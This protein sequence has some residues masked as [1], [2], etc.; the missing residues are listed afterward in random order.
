MSPVRR[1]EWASESRFA[2]AQG[3]GC[4]AVGTQLEMPAPTQ[5]AA[6]R[7]LEVVRNAEM[8]PPCDH[9]MQPILSSSIHPFDTRCST[10]LSTSHAS[11]TPRLR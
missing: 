3:D 6:K 1:A 11:P 8:Y 2:A 10:P 9:P 4:C 5:I 7:L